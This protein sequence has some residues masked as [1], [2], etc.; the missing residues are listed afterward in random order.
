[1]V[2]RG[3]RPGPRARRALGRS[4]LRDL[5]AQRTSRDLA[6]RRGDPRFRSRAPSGRVITRI[7]NIPVEIYPRLID[8]HSARPVRLRRR[9]AMAI[10]RRQAGE[11]P[12]GVVVITH[13]AREQLGQ[14]LPPLLRSPLRPR[15]LV[16]NSSSQD[17]TVETAAELGAETLVVPRRSFNHGLTRELARRRLGT[18]VVVMLTPDAHACADDFLER[19]TEPVRSW[20][21]RGG[22]RA[23]GRDLGLRPAGAGRARVQLP[24]REPCPSRR[25][26]G[27][28]GQLHPLLLQRRRR[29]VERGARPDRR[30]QAD[31]GVGGDH[32][33]RRAAGA[34]RA[35]RLRRRGGGP[36]CPSPWAGGCLPPAVRHRLQ[37]APLRLAPAGARGRR[38]ARPALRQ[39]RAGARGSRSAGGAAAD[40]RAPGSQLA[41]LPRRA[42]RASTASGTGASG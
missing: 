41:R 25:R 40:H 28:L 31:P 23:A 35:G 32:R 13:R 5:L 22:L 15:V 8:I 34:G 27:S 2:S 29:L 9:R 10:E 1:M 38:A 24:G 4:G 12:V 21:G 18:P 6:A 39:D 33:R 37:P 30:L 16:V 7:A 20:R 17:G 19:L 11:T 14:C 3:L 36:A 26:L 42:A